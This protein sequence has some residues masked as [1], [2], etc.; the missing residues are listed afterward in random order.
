MHEPER[1]PESGVSY[2]V[3]Y[4][5]LWRLYLEAL[6]HIRD[7]MDRVQRLEDQQRRKVPE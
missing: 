1:D 5:R 2:R 4:E 6:G 7:L 3:L